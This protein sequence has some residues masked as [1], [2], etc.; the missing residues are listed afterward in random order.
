MQG[1]DQEVKGRVKGRVQGRV[2]GQALAAAQDAELV[3]LVGKV[4]MVLG[5]GWPDVKGRYHWYQCC[6]RNENFRSRK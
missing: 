2:E 1:R 3:V 4:G 5:L 6:C